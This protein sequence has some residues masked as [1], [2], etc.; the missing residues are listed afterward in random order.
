M[1]SQAL[2]EP[3]GVPW[4]ADPWRGQPGTCHRVSG[5]AGRRWGWGLPPRPGCTHA[6]DLGT[7]GLSNG[8]RF[9]FRLCARAGGGG[10]FA[11]LLSPD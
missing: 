4:G 9:G 3:L 7:A 8:L 5:A 6:V 11:P 10:V 1:E 2:G